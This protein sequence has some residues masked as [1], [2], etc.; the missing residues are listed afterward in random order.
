MNSKE[1]DVVTID[2]G[3][4]FY[5]LWQKKVVIILVTLIFAWGGTSYPHLSSVR[6]MK[7]PRT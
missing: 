1:E 4:L 3:N 7:L 5:Q 6:N 2:L